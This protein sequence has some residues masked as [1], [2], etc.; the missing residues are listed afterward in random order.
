V[1]IQGEQNIS[2]VTF[3]KGGNTPITV[4]RLGD[5]LAYSEY[6]PSELSGYQQGGN[7]IFGTVNN[8][9]ISGGTGTGGT[10]IINTGTTN[11]FNISTGVTGDIFNTYNLSGIATG[12]FISIEAFGAVRGGESTQAIQ[13]A[14]NLAY[15]SG[16]GI[17]IPPYRYGITGTIYLPNKEGIK[18]QGAGGGYAAF[19][20]IIT[21]PLE[22]NKS[23]I[24][25]NGPTGGVM[26]QWAGLGV[27]WD[28][29]SLWGSSFT[30]GYKRGAGT[31]ILITKTGLGSAPGQHDVKTLT[32]L[33]CTVG[34]SCAPSGDFTMNNCEQSRWGFV[35]MIDCDQG[36][37]LNTEQA[38]GH[39]VDNY[40]FYRL[41]TT[42]QHSA[43]TVYGGGTFYANNYFGAAA[44]L[45]CLDIRGPGPGHNNG[46]YVFKNV[47]FD[48]GAG[49]SAKLLDMRSWTGVNNL[50]IPI[51]NARFQ[52][53]KIS[54][55]TYVAEGG[56]LVHAYAGTRVILDN[57]DK[58][59]NGAFRASSYLY[60]SN[61][62]SPNIQILNSR[63]WD[64][65][66]TGLMDTANSSGTY[67]W[68]AR[69]FCSFSGVPF[70]DTGNYVL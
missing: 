9:F 64:S 8:Y 22:G 59:Q 15:T 41:Y 49:G 18:F 1:A 25:W 27:S 46:A 40:N 56:F 36:F 20:G 38:I 32:V 37:Q 33:G 31:G 45:T 26:M 23:V 67:Y 53:V 4:N 62:Y 34:V 39:T 48:N 55:T 57:I 10:T 3:G 11:I 70:R 6:T 21:H 43:V 29:I 69:G 24:F 5:V 19:S 7:V 44:N 30:G 68:S 12:N 35:Y 54:A 52:D 58:I 14:V 65:T 66:P 63:G 47:K 28:A 60:G 16:F 17:F 61:L 2:G 51:V 42:G 50:D 13:N